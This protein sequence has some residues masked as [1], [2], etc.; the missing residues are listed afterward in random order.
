MKKN[1][2]F[3]WLMI[4]FGVFS[5]SATSVIIN[6]D[7]A[8]NVDV[9]TNYGTGNKLDLVNGINQFTLSDTDDSPLKITARTGAVI[10]S[11]MINETDKIDGTNGE[12]LVRFYSQGIKIDI[13]TSGSGTAPTEREVTINGFYSS[14][15]GV[16]GSPFTIT[17]E[18]DGEWLDAE[19]NTWNMYTI[20]ENAT[21]KVTPIAPYIINSLALRD[22]SFES[23]RQEDGSYTFTCTYDVFHYQNIYINMGLSPEA[24]RFSITVDYAPNISAALENQR[25]SAYQWLQLIN[26]KNDFACLAS[27]SPLEFFASEGASIVSM[28]RN[29]KTV[30]PIG[31]GGTNGWVFEL[32][33][34]DN[35]VV[36][37]QG[38]DV[39]VKVIAPEGNA[40]LEYYFFTS[41]TGSTFTP[42]GMESIIKTHVGEMIYISPRPG[43]KLTYIIHQNGGESD[44]MSSFRAA[45]GADGENL[46]TVS[47]YGTRNVSGVVI[48]TD[49]ASRVEVIQEGGRGDK[50]ELQNGENQFALADL[51]NALAVK[52]TEGNQMVEVT[53]NGNRIAPNASGVYLVNAKESDWIELITRKNPIDVTVDFTFNDGADISWI[54]GSVDGQEVSLTSPMTMKSYSSLY[55]SSKDGYILESVTSDTEGVIINKATDNTGYTV[56]IPNADITDVNINVSIK[57]TQPEEGNAIVVANGEEIFILYYEYSKSESGKYTFVKK[58]NNNT[59]NQVKL[60]NYVR[61]Y[62]KDTQS[63][64]LYVKANGTDVPLE[65]DSEDR[66]AYIQINGRT[67]IDAEIYTPC[68]AY[69]TES[70]DHIKH[71]VSGRIYFDI[72]GQNKTEIYPSAGQTVKFV[73]APEKGYIF[74][75]IELFYSLTIDSEGIVIEG[76]EYTFTE[77]DVKENFILFKGVFVE[78]PDEKV[79]AVKGS[80]AW[81]VDSDGNVITNSS[82]A[83]GNV[84]FINKTGEYVRETSGFE[85]EKIDLYVQVDEDVRDK[86][87]VDSYCLMNGFPNNKIKGSSYTVNPDDADNEG[88]IWICALVRELKSGTENPESNQILTYDAATHTVSASGPIKIFTVSGNLVIFSNENNV[89]VENLPAG[90]YIVVSGRKNLKF[91]K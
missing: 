35:F 83:M 24:V 15:E 51:K 78:N 72:D 69:T 70:F 6:V 30:N 75:H 3:T 55:V 80:T 89:S 81:L 47:V 43:T 41:S 63:R 59:V 77:S 60:G 22:G 42:E 52:A 65:T 17:Y 87:I 5:A 49:E 33:D 68:L 67:V 21:V 62:C 31:W 84:I 29:G 88:V 32:E 36:T 50:L 45:E 86:Y 7:N 54:K 91:I 57:E 90:T 66:I 2:L 85:G 73:P 37:T 64:F 74:D 56:T 79:Y 27:N 19:K 11:V 8:E 9:Y 12:Y 13:V 53:Q 26:G 34:G 71:L 61:V 25:E 82:G 20:P 39:D 1:L 28:T 18:K 76:N 23:T 16:T 10:E 40:P 48:E 4:L 44:M 46:M 58:L 14:G 38:K